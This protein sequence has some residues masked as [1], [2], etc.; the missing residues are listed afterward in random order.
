MLWAGVLSVQWHQQKSHNVR[1]CSIKSVENVSS[2]SQL[3][4]VPCVPNV[5]CVAG[6]PPV[7]ARLQ[8]FWSVW[9]QRGADQRVVQI[10]KE[11]YTLPFKRRP[12]LVRF[13]IIVNHNH[14][15]W[16][17]MDALHALL[18]R[19]TVE[20]VK[21]CHSL[22]F[23]NRLFLVPKS[24]NKWRPILDLSILNTSLKVT[25]LNGHS[26]NHTD[27]S[28]TGRVCHFRG[29][30]GCLFPH[31]DSSTFQE[32]PQIPGPRHYL[33]IQSSPFRSID[34]SYGW[35]CILD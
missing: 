21:I 1:F 16:H 20:Q 3:P 19:N 22:A 32:V 8:E 34:S 5:P 30:H 24:N 13:P 28:S 2:A 26:R 35:S 14:R 4:R 10:L 6:N 17:L 12:R 15:I 9:A 7:G 29:C 18:Q 11:G 23:Y 25:T 33:P 31:P 27:L